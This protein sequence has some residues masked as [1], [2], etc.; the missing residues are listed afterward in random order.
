MTFQFPT[1]PS[2][3]QGQWETIHYRRAIDSYEIEGGLVNNPLLQAWFVDNVCDV[4]LGEN[5]QLR[6]SPRE[7]FEKLEEISTSHDE[8][9][10]LQEC[11]DAKDAHE[12]FYQSE[13]CGS[14]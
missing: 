8:Y 14:L 12:F 11:N 13:R 4:L 5:A 9:T 1:P 2:P 6:Y 7:L 10:N 3:K